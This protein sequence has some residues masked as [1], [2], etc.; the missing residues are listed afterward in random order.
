[1][2]KLGRVLSSHA[3][4]SMW[5]GIKAQQNGMKELI[6]SRVRYRESEGKVSSK[7]Q[8]TSRLKVKTST[9]N[10]SCLSELKLFFFFAAS[11]FPRSVQEINGNKTVYDTLTSPKQSSTG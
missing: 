1:M 4:R 10:S 3:L 5:S 2:E 8:I 9:A 11:L 6:L 7:V